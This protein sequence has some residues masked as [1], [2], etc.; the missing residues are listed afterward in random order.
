MSIEQASEPKVN[1]EKL[2]R[3]NADRLIANIILYIVNLKSHRYLPSCLGQ[4]TAKG[5][6]GVRVKLP[7]DRSCLPH[8]VEASHC[9]F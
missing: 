3:K 6:F 5:P 2:T 4:E 9:P 8:T 7:P 1:P